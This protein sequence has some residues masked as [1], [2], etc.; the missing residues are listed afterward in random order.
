MY[1][2]LFKKNILYLSTGLVLR[3]YF[4]EYK[5]VNILYVLDE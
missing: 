5:S 4:F 2:D 3:I 1:Y